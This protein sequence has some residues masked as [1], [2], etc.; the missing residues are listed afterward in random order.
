MTPQARLKIRS[1]SPTPEEAEFL[2]A[3]EP[4]Q[5]YLN[6]L[7]AEILRKFAG[8]WIAAR[9]GKFVAAAATRAKLGEALGDA[10]D[11]ATLKLR[12]EAGVSIRWRSPS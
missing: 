6:D 5:R 1:W 4:T 10:D 11:A 12:L 8:Q 7:P 3:V 9:D 2:R